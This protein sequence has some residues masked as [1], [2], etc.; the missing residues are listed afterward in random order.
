MGTITR[1]LHPGGIFIG[2]GGRF[3]NYHN[4]IADTN[5]MQ[6]IQSIDMPNPGYTGYPFDVHTGVIFQKRP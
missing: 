3:N 6:L 4:E 1:I 5:P 2:S